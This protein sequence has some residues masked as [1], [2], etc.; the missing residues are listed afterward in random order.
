MK[1]DDFIEKYKKH[2]NNDFHDPEQ[3]GYQVYVPDEWLDYIDAAL[4]AMLAWKGKSNEIITLYEDFQIHQIKEKFGG[5][6]FY[7]SADSENTEKML[8]GVVTAL[9]GVIHFISKNS[10]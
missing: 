7:F 1:V 10:H 3:F 8:E 5:L 6:R 4:E 2:F 9:E